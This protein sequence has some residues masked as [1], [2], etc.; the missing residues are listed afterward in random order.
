MISSLKRSLKIDICYAVNS[1]IYSI[2]KLPILDNLITDDIYKS[3]RLKG[4]IR[5]IS[6]ILSFGKMIVGRLLYCLVI[7]L[8]IISYLILH[9]RNIYQY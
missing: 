6:L 3:K 7:C 2:R 5:I 8:L 1:F 9:R 4:I